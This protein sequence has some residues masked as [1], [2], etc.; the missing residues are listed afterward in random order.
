M[1]TMR[2]KF[3]KLKGLKVAV[4]GD[5]K[6]SR[7][8]MSN[9]FGLNKFGAN[10]YAYAPATMV[11]KEFARLGVTVAKSR[12]EAVEGAD[13][14]MGLRIQLERQNGG[15]F[16]SLSEYAKFYGVNDEVLKY[17]KKDAIALHPGPVNRGVELSPQVI[18]GEKSLILEQVT[19]GVAVRMSILKLLAQYREANLF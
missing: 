4:L 11:P 13:V 5:L 9:A 15:L 3:G 18:D 10:V 2:E 17:A 1:F 6:H 12:E 7:V 19:N 8:A 14:V 16:P